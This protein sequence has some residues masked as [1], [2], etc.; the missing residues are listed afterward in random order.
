MGFG[1]LGSIAAQSSPNVGLALAYYGMTWKLYSTIIARG[2][3]V[4]FD[5]NAAVDIS[6]NTTR[7]AVNTA[8][9]HIAK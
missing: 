4:R 9:K 8:E 5:K 2:Q 3:E 6:F 1:L 7:P